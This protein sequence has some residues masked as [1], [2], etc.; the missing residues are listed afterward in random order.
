MVAASKMR[1]AQV[2]V[3]NSRGVVEPFV[4]L[5][6]DFPAYDPT[7]TV[8]V[9]VTSDR[10]LCGGL[11]SSITKYTRSLLKMYTGS[12]GSASAGGEGG[13]SSSGGPVQQTLV[14]IG[15]KGRSQLSR[16]EPDMLALSFADTY[17]TRVTF[18][19]ASVLAEEVLKASAWA[20]AAA[21]GGGGAGGAAPA[22]TPDA[23]R[24]LFNKFGS[25]I[26]FKPTVATV[27]SPAA[28]ERQMTTET[29]S[30]LDAYE[31]EAAGEKNDALQD[32]VE[33][34]LAAT[35]FNAMLENN[36]S[37]HGSRMSAMENS[38]KSAGEML[39]ALT[40]KYNRDRQATITT[41][42]IEI[43]AG[44]SALMDE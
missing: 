22:P 25:A 36:C 20:P 6:G 43:I 28:V 7:R 16:V 13:G 37:E 27:L 4:R 26:S 12:A 15:D 11:N 19:Q 17:K 44:A 41:E 38:T 18:A 35:L 29:G 5:F 24:V 23:V 14:T 21:A 40:L 33:L 2:A 31:L 42:L 34:Q 39:G 3:E 9:A 32:L 30:K 10:G 1:N 8:T